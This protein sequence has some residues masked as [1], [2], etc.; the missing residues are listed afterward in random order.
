MFVVTFR[1]FAQLCCVLG[2]PKMLKVAHVSGSVYLVPRA[3]NSAPG[4]SE[5]EYPS[6]EWKGGDDG[7][8]TTKKA[9]AITAD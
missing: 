9:T 5:G 2:K 7:G 3:A 1:E 4:Q 6:Q 8:G